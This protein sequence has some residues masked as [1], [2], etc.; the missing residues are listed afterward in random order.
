MARS[1]IAGPVWGSIQHATSTC[2]HTMRCAARRCMWLRI[3]CRVLG[4]RF[5]HVYAP[6]S[7]NVLLTRIEHVYEVCQSAL[8]FVAVPPVVE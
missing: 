6:G 7:S 8:G 4:I 5:V 3:T 2:S 1:F